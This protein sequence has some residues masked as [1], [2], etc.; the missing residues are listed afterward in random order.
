MDVLAQMLIDWEACS[1]NGSVIPAWRLQEVLD[2]AA[3][4]I[5]DSSTPAD[6]QEEA[7][8][9]LEPSADAPGLLQVM[10][11]RPLGNCAEHAAQGGIEFMRFWQ[12]WQELHRALGAG[13][14]ADKAPVVEELSIFRDAL[15]RCSQQGGISAHR[16]AIAVSAARGMSADEHAWKPLEESVVRLD[17]ELF[18]FADVPLDPGGL[19]ALL[20]VWLKDLIADYQ[21][22]TRADKLRAVRDVCKCSVLEACLQ[23]GPRGWEVEQ[24][25]RG[26]YAKN[27]VCMEELPDGR[28]KGGLG[29]SSQGMR[30]RQ[31]EVECP[32]CCE[33]FG[34]GDGERVPAKC[35]FQVMCR[36]CNAR[37]QKSATKTC[38]FCRSEHKE[39][40]LK[41]QGR[42]GPSS[43]T[44]RSSLASR[45]FRF[46]ASS[47]P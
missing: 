25:L 40:S 4:H 32:I 12:A 36:S 47:L 21:S 33:A 18:P 35:C 29:W 38:P 27:G 39:T 11:L 17:S 14:E 26:F 15:I 23:L 41:L 10:L 34:T 2:R 45:L 1:P 30:L 3:A 8:L 7:F 24:A 20:L 37:L 31:T 6:L 16:L 43:P 22:G 19:C 5:L 9:L 44:S 13:S 42:S 28:G 46:A